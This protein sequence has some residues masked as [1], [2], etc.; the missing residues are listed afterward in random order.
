[1]TEALSRLTG[2]LQKLQTKV[3]TAK[4]EG[5][6]VA[7]AQSAIDAAQKAIE[8]AQTAV[9]TQA[10]KNY[11]ANVTDET[12]VKKE[13]SDVINAFRTDMQ[14]TEKSIRSARDSVRD[15]ARAV[16]KLKITINEPAATPSAS[17]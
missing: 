11:T 5:Q 7:A 2:V 4:T 15:A 12:T 17:I 8:D 16:Y 14:T 13:L 6:D 3:D 9:A 10:S 1:M